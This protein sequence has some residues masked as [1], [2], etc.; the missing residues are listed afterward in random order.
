MADLEGQTR[1][2]EDLSLGNDSTRDWDTE[3]GSST[4]T[5]KH[6]DNESGTGML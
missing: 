2:L 3:S 4:D 1:A 5:S 6:T